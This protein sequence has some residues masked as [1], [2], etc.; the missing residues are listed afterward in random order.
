MKVNWLK[1]PKVNEILIGKQAPIPNQTADTAPIRKTVV[2]QVDGM[3][4]GIC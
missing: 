1:I 2:A 4:F 3:G